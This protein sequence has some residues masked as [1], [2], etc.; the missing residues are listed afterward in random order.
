MYEYLTGRL[1]ERGPD[2][3]VL[4]IGGVGYR[5]AISGATSARLPAPGSEGVTLH[6]HD[7]LRDE[8]LLLYG[9]ASREERALFLRLLGVSRVGPAMALSLLSALEP[10]ALAGA[11]QSGDVAALARV[12]G[13]GKR[14]AERL[15]V[16]LKGRLDGVMA[17]PGP[18]T[19]RRAALEAA[20][21]ALGY[22]RGLAR[23]SAERVCAAAGPQVALEALVRQGLRDLAG[24]GAAA[25]GASA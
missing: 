25:D 1:V 13:I 10:A 18:L 7:V 19:D 14:T 3:A 21:L 12:R 6:V 8:R 9:F 5:L 15:C 16:E 22:A 20:L 23:A 2:E 24:Q 11:V 17:L 4:D